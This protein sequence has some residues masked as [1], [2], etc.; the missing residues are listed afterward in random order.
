MEANEN[1]KKVSES[2]KKH[3][4]PNKEPKQENKQQ[5]QEDTYSDKA[6]KATPNFSIYFL[7]G[8]TASLFFLV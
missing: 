3:Q 7:A 8:S 5:S 2:T 4:Q 6:N 1:Q